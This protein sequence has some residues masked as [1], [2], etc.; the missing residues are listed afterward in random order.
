MATYTDPRGP[1][2]EITSVERH[3]DRT[4]VM[5]ECGHVN[6][7]NQIYTYEVGSLTRCFQC[8]KEARLAQA[9]TEGC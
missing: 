6:R 2:R 7:C 5:C 3:T 1:L 8:V 9:R 4:D